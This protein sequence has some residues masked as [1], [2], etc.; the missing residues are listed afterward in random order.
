[1]SFTSAPRALKKGIDGLLTKLGQGQGREARGP[2]ARLSDAATAGADLAADHEAPS[3]GAGDVLVDNADSWPPVAQ[4]TAQA[5]EALRERERTSGESISAALVWDRGQAA[6][7][8]EGFGPMGGEGAEEEKGVEAEEE[9]GYEGVGEGEAEEEKG[10][11]HQQEGEEGEEVEEEEEDV[12]EGFAEAKDAGH[13]APGSPDGQAGQPE[14]VRLRLTL[15][16]LSSRPHTTVPAEPEIESDFR[17]RRDAERDVHAVRRQQFDSYHQLIAAQMS[18]QKSRGVPVDLYFG[19]GAEEEPESRGARDAWAGTFG[20]SPHSPLSLAEF[21]SADEGYPRKTV[22]PVLY[23]TFTRGHG[24]GQGQTMTLLIAS[25]DPSKGPAPS[26]PTNPPPS[27]SANAA[28]RAQREGG[29]KKREERARRLSW[30]LEG[31]AGSSAG[32]RPASPVSAL[33]AQRKVVVRQAGST[34]AL[35]RKLE[36]LDS[37]ALV[38][39]V[40]KPAGRK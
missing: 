4:S 26:R 3:P 17:H 20:P 23:P 29:A 34:W 36:V 30:T 33:P 1:M 11:E 9:K 25:D 16:A 31:H 24:D 27:S 28:L 7:E 22:D 15:Q 2:D 18:A 32:P 13:E 39:T 21:R 14:D 37:R 38:P 5:L 35:E 6:G 8:D 19:F 12:G 40:T 10:S